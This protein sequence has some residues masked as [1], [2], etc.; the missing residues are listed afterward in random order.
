MV[1]NNQHKYSISALCHVLQLPRSTYYYEATVKQSEDQ[2]ST[3]IQD[4]FHG[5][6]QNDGTRK[7]KVELKKQ[8]HVVSRRRIAR[9]MRENGLVSAYTVA[10]FKPQKTSCNEAKIANKLDREFQQKNN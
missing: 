2:L 10:H 8:G 3:I 4:I 9:I 5:S 1:R 6:R 7:I